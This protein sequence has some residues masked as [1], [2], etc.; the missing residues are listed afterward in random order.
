MAAADAFCEAAIKVVANSETT[1]IIAKIAG[2]WFI[3]SSFIWSSLF[4]IE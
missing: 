3:L 1:T 2:V 4:F